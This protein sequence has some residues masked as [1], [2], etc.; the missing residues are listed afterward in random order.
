[1]FADGGNSIVDG[2]DADGVV[3]PMPTRSFER[4]ANLD[5]PVDIREFVGLH[6]ARGL[7]NTGEHADIGGERLL[8][9][10]TRPQ[11]AAIPTHVGGNRRRA[12]GFGQGDCLIQEGHPAPAVIAGDQCSTGLTEER[13]ALLDLP[14]DL[15]LVEAR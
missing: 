13:I 9:A 6:V 15:E 3:G 12:R 5:R 10:E 8:E 1:M 7:A 4:Y 2:S 11:P 14:D